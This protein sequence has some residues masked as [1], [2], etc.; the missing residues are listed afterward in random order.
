MPTKTF[1]PTE[2]DFARKTYLVDAK[3]KVI[4]SHLNFQQGSTGFYL[5]GLS[6]IHL[7][8]EKQVGEHAYKPLQETR[9]GIIQTTLHFLSKNQMTF[10]AMHHAGDET[11]SLMV[12]Y[13]EEVEKANHLIH[14]KRVVEYFQTVY[15]NPVEPC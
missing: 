5:D 3:G 7:V 8:D 2:K 4:A 15:E 6:K 13:L 9:A 1:I 12:K 11:S 14:E 10:A